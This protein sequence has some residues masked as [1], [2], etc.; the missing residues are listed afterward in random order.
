MTVIAVNA[1]RP[2]LATGSLPFPIVPGTPVTIMLHGYRYTPASPRKDPHLTIYAGLPGSQDSRTLSW[3]RRLGLT[4]A[5][6]GIGFGWHADGTIWSAHAGAER[7]GLALAD[8]I[9]GLRAQG[10]GPVNLFGH[11]LGCR[12]ALSSLPHLRA[13]DVGR[14]VLMS[15]AA[16]R[17]QATAA[18]ATPAGRAAAV[19]NVTSRENDLYNKAFELLIFR[20][21]DL[22][23]GAGLDAPN[24]VTLQIDHPHHREG[25]RA[26]GF[27]TAAPVRRVCHW[28]AYMRPG[29]FPLYRAFLHRPASLT[30]ADLRRALR[31]DAAPRWSRLI[32]SPLLGARLAAE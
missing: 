17:G 20:A 19:L 29:L 18:L 1:D 16:L 30:L 6:P 26:L 5:R 22:T 28:S 13:A 2:R 4:G 11:S 10:A 24:A 23:L 3:P 14:I 12:V 8:L 31:A 32:A 7:A 27:P 15:A 25:L 9:A 21:G